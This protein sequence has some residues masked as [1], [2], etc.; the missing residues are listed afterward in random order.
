M[1]K[2]AED[3]RRSQQ[4]L[5][6]TTPTTGEEQ[7]RA[8]QDIQMSDEE[9][10]RLQIQQDVLVDMAL[11]RQNQV[12]METTPTTVGDRLRDAKNTSL[13]EEDQPRM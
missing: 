10:K 7:P 6:E 9:Q 2:T 5:M 8:A 11:Q 13:S 12:L 4:V 3:P 1:E